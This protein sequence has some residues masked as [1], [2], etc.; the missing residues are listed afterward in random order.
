MP[1]RV[2][3]HASRITNH[4][5]RII[6]IAAFFIFYALSA[7]HIRAQQ[8]IEGSNFKVGELFDPPNEQQLKSLIE[9]ARWRHQGSQTVVYDAKVQSFRTNGAVQIIIEAPESFY[10]ETRKA[11]NSSGPVQFRTADGQ[12]FLSGVGFLWLQTNSTLYISNQVKTVVLSTNSPAETNKGA[13]I[14]SDRFQY[15]KDSGIGL[16]SRNVP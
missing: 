14:F 7:K 6:L 1:S 4:A 16:Y 8:P 2:L 9:G 11:V 5:S 13:T 12:F 3:Y 10:D 15:A